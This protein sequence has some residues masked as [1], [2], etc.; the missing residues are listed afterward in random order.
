MSTGK[1]LVAIIIHLMVPLLGVGTY[2]LLVRRMLRDDIP[3][4]PIIELFV[5]F[6]IYGAGLLIALTSLFWVWS[7]AASLGALFLVFGA[8]IVMGFIAYRTSKRKNQSRYHQWTYA[9]GWSYLVFLPFILL[10]MYLI[11]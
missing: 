6:A 4:P 11:V 9:L 10:T 8:P 2:L 1:V 5:I 3:N 7:G